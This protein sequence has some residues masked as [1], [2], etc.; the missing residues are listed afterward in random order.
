MKMLIVCL[1]L[2]PLA[3]AYY[4]LESAIDPIKMLYTTTG[5]GAICLL[6]LSLVPST[7]KRVCGVNFLR[8][9][10]SIGLLS[11]FQRKY[12]RESK[13]SKILSANAFSVYLIHAPIIVLLSYALQAVVL[14]PLL[15][16]TLASVIAVPLCFLISNFIVLKI[17]L[18]NKIL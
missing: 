10:K 16:F 1:A 2:L 17:P 18:A 7:C 11:F 12:N 4:T 8:Y 6:L 3:Y 15:K 14:H 5:V 13:F 9:R